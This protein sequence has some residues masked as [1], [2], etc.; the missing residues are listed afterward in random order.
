M[1]QSN[2]EYV[3]VNENKINHRFIRKKSQLCQDYKF[4]KQHS[5]KVKIGAVFFKR[6][7][8]SLVLLKSDFMAFVL[9]K[10]HP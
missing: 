6:M 4:R 3:S 8:Y 9:K 1:V 7:P 2:V 5:D 10:L